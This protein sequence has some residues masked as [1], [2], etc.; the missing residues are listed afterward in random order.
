[1]AGPCQYKEWNVKYSAEK[2][3]AAGN[4]VRRIKTC[5]SLFPGSQVKQAW[6]DLLKIKTPLLRGFSSLAGGNTYV[7][8]IIYSQLITKH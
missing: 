8:E 5:E 3:Y 2:G 6:A 7:F 4:F 1:M